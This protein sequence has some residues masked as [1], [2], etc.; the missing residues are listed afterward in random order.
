MSYVNKNIKGKELFSIIKIYAIWHF[1][2]FYNALAKGKPMQQ[3]VIEVLEDMRPI[4]QDD[5]KDIQLVEI[6]ENNTVKVRLSGRCSQCPKSGHAL[7]SIVM[8]TI[9]KLVPQVGKVEILT[10]TIS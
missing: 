8:K 4:L 5:E 3:K 6:T 1:I 10:E 2:E 7:H 9:L